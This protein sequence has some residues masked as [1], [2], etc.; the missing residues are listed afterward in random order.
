MTSHPTPNCRARTDFEATRA[1]QLW[2]TNVTYAS[3]RARKKPEFSCDKK[4]QARRQ[5]RTDPASPKQAADRGVSIKPK[6]RQQ[7][8]RADE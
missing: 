7:L 1:A 6:T 3:R 8:Q 5:D 2:D 4:T